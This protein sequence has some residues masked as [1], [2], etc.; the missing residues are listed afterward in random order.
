MQNMS[1]KNAVSKTIAYAKR[2][3]VRAAFFAA[4]ERV[5]DNRRDKYVFTPLSEA[6][7]AEQKKEYKLLAQAGDLV[8]FSIVVPLYNTPEKY[9]KEM[10]ESVIAQTYGNWE[11]VLADASERPLEVAKEYS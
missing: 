5:G 3:G 11:L 4:L 10:I 9:L 6:V 7:L 8:R 2:N 1:I